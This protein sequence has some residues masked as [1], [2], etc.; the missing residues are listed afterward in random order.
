MV[1]QGPTSLRAVIAPK[2]LAAQR[3]AAACAAEPVGCWALFSSLSALLGT[4][5]Q[6]NYAAANAQLD[7]YAGAQNHAG[8]QHTYKLHISL[9][10][11]PPEEIMVALMRCLGWTLRCAV[12]YGTCFKH[13]TEHMFF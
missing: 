12:R 7:A 5:G 11:A 9:L 3:L 10:F 6:A 1:A 4:P 8:E 13:S 2:L